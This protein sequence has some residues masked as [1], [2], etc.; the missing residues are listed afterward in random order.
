MGS[1]LAGPLI[2]P[3]IR[4]CRLQLAG[5]SI[6]VVDGLELS[7]QLWM[8]DSGGS[9]SALLFREQRPAIAKLSQCGQ[10]SGPGG[11]AAAAW[12]PPPES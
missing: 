5:L 6:M 1:L 9:R 2:R 4:D 12:P 7:C 8:S 3:L 10:P 11:A